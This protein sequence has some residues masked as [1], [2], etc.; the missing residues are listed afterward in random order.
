MRFIIEKQEFDDSF[1]TINRIIGKDL[2]LPDLVFKKQWGNF[3]FITFDEIF[4]P[5]VFFRNLKEFLKIKLEDYFQLSVINPDPEKYFFK[6]FK[7]YSMLHFSINDR[8]EDYLEILNRDPGNSPADSIMDNSN[9]ILVYSDNADWGVYGERELG[10]AI[11]AFRNVEL[12]NLFETAYG[13]KLL[14][15][16]EAFKLMGNAYKDQL[17]P[18]KVEKKIRQNYLGS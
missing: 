6:H 5:E 1:Q 15:L 9:S 3:L 7:K 2:E 4:L 17:L 12:K 13:N 14:N 10:V 8:E 11:C 18:I 16:E